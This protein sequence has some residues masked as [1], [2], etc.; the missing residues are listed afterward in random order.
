VGADRCALEGYLP[1][2]A[3]EPGVMQA[4]A[5]PSCAWNGE[6]LAARGLEMGRRP[7]WRFK[8]PQVSGRHAA[9]S[10]AQGAL[11]RPFE[12]GAQP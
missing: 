9:A 5:R 10:V 11:D 4:R 8:A 12:R 1:V 3:S 7:S 2:W 6:S